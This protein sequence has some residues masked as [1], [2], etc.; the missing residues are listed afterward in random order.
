[1]GH[2]RRHGNG[3]DELLPRNPA[4]QRR[5]PDTSFRRYLSQGDIETAA[6]V[7]R[8]SRRDDLVPVDGRIAP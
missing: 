5:E 4:V 7:N 2:M 6:R 3:L 8:P 1:M